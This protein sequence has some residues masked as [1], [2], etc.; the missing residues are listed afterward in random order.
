ML[1]ILKLLRY[2]RSLQTHFQ[3][4][5]FPSTDSNA[6]PTCTHARFGHDGTSRNNQPPQASSTPINEH[7]YTLVCRT[8]PT[9]P[10]N[11]RDGHRR[12]NSPTLTPVE[13]WLQENM[14]QEP[15]N[16]VAS[17]KS[18]QTWAE[19]DVGEQIDSKGWS[20]EVGDESAAEGK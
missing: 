16:N 17:Y 2:F 18:V 11:T 4:N 3:S 13:R 19:M 1:A 10:D 20:M 12:Y 6:P 5:K 8:W 7:G 15:W 14:Q 9:C